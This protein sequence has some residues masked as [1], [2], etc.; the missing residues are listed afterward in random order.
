MPS[1]AHAFQP[2]SN[3]HEEPQGLTPSTRSLGGPT[4][5]QGSQVHA[6]HCNLPLV[7]LLCSAVRVYVSVCM[8]LSS[9][10]ITFTKIN[11]CL[12]CHVWTCVWVSFACMACMLIFLF[13]HTLIPPCFVLFLVFCPVLRPLASSLSPPPPSTP[14]PFFIPNKL[15]F[16]HHF[17]H[18]LSSNNTKNEKSLLR[19]QCFSSAPPSLLLT[20][21]ITSKLTISH[22]LLM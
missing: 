12:S 16:R 18:D 6:I 1:D 13:A 3:S 8:C 15:P 9:Q 5:T 20:P 2:S 19:R 4:P 17:N 21:V 11:V 22:L 10:P 14:W 7:S